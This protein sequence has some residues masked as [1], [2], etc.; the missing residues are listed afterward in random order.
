M[1]WNP[2]QYHKFQSQRAAPFYDLLKLVHVKPRLKV[3]DLGCGTGELTKE[4]ADLLPESNVTGLDSSAHMLEKAASFS[5]GSLS[6]EQGNLSTLTQPYDLIF[7]NA[8]VQ[9]VEDHPRLIPHLFSKLNPGGQICIQMPS[10]HNHVSHLLI[11]ET[12]REEPFKTIL[13]GFERLAPVLQ[14]DE[15]AKMLF[16]L[17]ADE[18]VSFEKVYPHVLENSDAVIEWIKGTALV[19]YF[20]RLG[21]HKE[22]YLDILKRKM[23]AALPESPVFYPFRRILFSAKRAG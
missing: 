13:G 4:L 19:P 17:G 3:I 7:S 20:E 5:T 2:D 6:F 12:A 11:R 16:Q 10:N 1:P 15:Y 8:A 22:E 14:V 23:K 18:I 21:E 9:W